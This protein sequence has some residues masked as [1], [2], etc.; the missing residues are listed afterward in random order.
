[1]KRYGKKRFIVLAAFLTLIIS[2]RELLA[3]GSLTLAV[4][5]YQADHVLI[6]KFT[7]LARYLEKQT[8]LKIK[9]R[10]GSSYDEHI[11]YIGQDKVDI[12][13]MGPASY[14]NMVN[15]YSNK[16][17]LARLEVNGFSYF[18][19]NII[20]RKGSGIKSLDDLKGKRIAFGDPNSTMSY[21]VPHYILHKAGVFGDQ[22]NK[23]EFLYSHNNV[24]LG[25]LVGDFDAGA[26]KPSV[27]KK[28]ESKGLI[29]IAMTPKISEHLFVTRSNLPK[30]KIDALRQ[31][32]LNV[33]KHNS[34]RAA[35]SEIKKSITNLVATTKND[36]VNL[37]EIIL[38]S[39][40]L[41]K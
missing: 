2:S 5:P 35:L 30:N 41:H 19:G 32:M 14:V 21:I 36:Y 25:I 3:D 31:A 13:Y 11:R 38:D 8:G 40:K 16:P 26:V 1:M 28:F 17:I 22:L 15:E 18:Q 20:A 23:H 12:A 37:R 6:K 24:A 39:R 10:V 7:P 4:H 34:G 9:V 33:K 29:T 27:F